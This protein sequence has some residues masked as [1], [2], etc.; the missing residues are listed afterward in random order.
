M[1]SARSLSNVMH[2]SNAMENLAMK[3]S[4]TVAC[5]GGGPG[6]D[7]LGVLDYF[8]KYMAGFEGQ[9]NIHLY[10]REGKWGPCWE[11]LK[12]AIKAELH[13]DRVAVSFHDFDVTI[14]TAD[15]NKPDLEN[16]DLITMHYFM[17]E[18]F[19]ERGKTNG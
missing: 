18:V 8:M 1:V 14:A 3:P 11:S 7:V 12:T 13:D 10:D 6:S 16:A 5:L 19:S 15:K 17:E 4:I 2:H 9:L